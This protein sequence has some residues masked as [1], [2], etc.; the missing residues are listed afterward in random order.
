MELYFSI[1]MPESILDRYLD[2]FAWVGGETYSYVG[3]RVLWVFLRLGN[4]NDFCVFPVNGIWY[5]S[6]WHF[7]FNPAK[8]STLMIRIKNSYIFHLSSWLVGYMGLTFSYTGLYFVL[9]MNFYQYTT[10]RA[11]NHSSD[12]FSCTGIVTKAIRKGR[13]NVFI[14]LE[15][16][17]TLGIANPYTYSVYTGQLLCPLFYM[18]EDFGTC[19]P[20]QT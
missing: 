3:C 8:C 14:R 1:V 13:M 17:V 6:E 10:K 19:A 2:C 15:P 18:A 11:G 20:S 9:G 12:N 7:H 16:W 4:G 5:P